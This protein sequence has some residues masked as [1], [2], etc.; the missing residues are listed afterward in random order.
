[1]VVY[2]GKVICIPVKTFNVQCSGDLVKFPYD[3]QTCV[4]EFDVLPYTTREI[5]VS[6]YETDIGSY[7]RNPE[8]KLLNISNMIEQ[9]FT[10]YSNTTYEFTAYKITIQRHS[11]YHNM[12][13]MLPAIGKC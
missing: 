10:Q 2:K 12:V 9:R 8:W 5:N 7:E 13:I 1:M 4:I 3:T 11:A 6:I